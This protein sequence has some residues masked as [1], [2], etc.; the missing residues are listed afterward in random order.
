MKYKNENTDVL[1]EA[2]LSLR[3]IDE[4]YD[5]FTDACTLKEI[6]DM[7]QRF[8]VARMLKEKYSYMMINEK[9]GVSTATIGRVNRSL[10]YGA[11]GYNTIIDRLKENKN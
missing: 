6:K 4:C 1:F 10:M 9:T 11:D 7:S 2:I 8:E 3:S 5:F